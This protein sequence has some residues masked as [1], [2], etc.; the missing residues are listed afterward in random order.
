[1]KTS[2]AAG[3]QNLVTKRRRK[4]PADGVRA[5]DS[6]MLKIDSRDVFDMVPP[7][8]ESPRRMG[9]RPAKGPPPSNILGE[10]QP[11]PRWARTEATDRDIR[12]DV[13]AA[14]FRAGANLLAL[15]RILR[16]GEAGAEPPF[17]GALRQ[18]L[19][20]KAAAACARRARLREDEA[21]LRDAE[22]LCGGASAAT[23][24]GGRLHRLW[25][26]IAALPAI[27][28]VATLQTALGL[29]GM[30]DGES[31]QDLADALQEIVA[32][33]PHPLAA[34][35]GA[36]LVA[37]RRFDVANPDDA[38][39]ISLW[40]ADAALAQKLGWGCAVP[41]VATAITL[42][43][44][45]DGRRSRIGDPDW[46][47]ALSLA[48]ALS[49]QQ[50]FDIAADLFRRAHR[51]SNVALKL[52]AKGASRVIELLLA[53]D[54]VAPARAAKQARLSDRAARR[55]FDRLV[56]LD[57]VRELSGRPTFRLY[58]L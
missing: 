17:A 10:I 32:K 56:E 30:P 33:A 3:A 13:Q 21:A 37:S 53:D 9:R 45:R 26:L 6:R 7:A 52:R 38:E 48:Y 31:A 29:L 57:A 34:A 5:Y 46:S 47:D 54:C 42:R 15:D 24:P 20:L 19:A 4:L 23:S 40:V 50:A 11:L 43:K 51:L 39:I 35:A 16:A 27:L 14:A 36:S 18:R 1:M 44:D 25:R 55:L 8:A 2:A 12:D 28:N 22:H 41:L 49:A 58:G